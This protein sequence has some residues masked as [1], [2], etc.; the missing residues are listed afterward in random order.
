[1]YDCLNNSIQAI[2]G[3]YARDVIKLCEQ[4]TLSV[5]GFR[6]ILVAAGTNDLCDTPLDEI[7]QIFRN[8]IEYVRNKKNHCRLAISGILPRACDHQLIP[9]LQRRIDTN[10]SLAA[11]CK[12]QH[13]AYLKTEL[14]IKDKGPIPLIYCP[15]GIHLTDTGIG[16]VKK[17][18][19]GRIGS[20]LG[21][22]PQW[23]PP[24]IS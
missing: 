5:A 14:A 13:V 1:M 23:T 15:D 22:P 2:P 16:L 18:I 17:W 20:L 11:L 7:I 19:E 12:S 21:S 10:E 8:I 9:K 4:G 24:S 6:V 3:A